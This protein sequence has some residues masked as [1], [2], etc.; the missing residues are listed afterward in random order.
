MPSRYLNKLDALDKTDSKYEKYVSQIE[1]EWEEELSKMPYHERPVNGDASESAIIKFFQPIED[2]KV[3]RE[4][5]IL[6]K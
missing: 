3:V 6:G 4:R 5:H 1:K 2:V